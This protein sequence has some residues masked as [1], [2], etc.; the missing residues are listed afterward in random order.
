VA[1]SNERKKYIESGYKSG[2]KKEAVYI[3]NGVN[4]PQ[5]ENWNDQKTDEQGDGDK[6]GIELNAPGGIV[7]DQPGEW[8][9]GN[10]KSKV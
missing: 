10:G 5:I 8:R 2:Y 7:Q 3:T 6:E 4:I 9:N 1:D